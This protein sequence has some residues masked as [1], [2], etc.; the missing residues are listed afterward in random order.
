MTRVKG[1]EK[2]RLWLHVEAGLL[3]YLEKRMKRERRHSINDTVIALI[4]E[5]IDREVEARLN[6]EQTKLEG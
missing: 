4:E 5:E 3:A 6:L 1:P 2:K